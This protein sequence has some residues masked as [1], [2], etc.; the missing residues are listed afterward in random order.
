MTEVT[1]EKAKEVMDFIA[2]KLGCKWAVMGRIGTVYIETGR[3]MLQPFLFVSSNFPPR[4]S[5][6]DIVD[7]GGSWRRAVEKVLGKMCFT[8]F[9]KGFQCPESL[10]ELLVQMDIEG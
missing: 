10:E 3:D 1:E 8:S 4:M 6:S 5:P 9:S 2:K 7:S